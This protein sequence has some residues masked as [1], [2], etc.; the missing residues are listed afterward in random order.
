MRPKSMIN[1][2]NISAN[3]LEKNKSNNKNKSL[4]AEDLK[5]HQNKKRQR[6][7]ISVTDYKYHQSSLTEELKAN[8]DIEVDAKAIN[9]K[10]MVKLFSV[11]WLLITK[12]WSFR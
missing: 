10:G 8:F 5:D 4:N 11:V 2:N 7:I 6:E 9:F 12:S 3:R 1:N